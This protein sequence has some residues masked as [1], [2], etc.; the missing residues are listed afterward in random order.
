MATVAGLREVENKSSVSK[1]F[2]S[3]GLMRIALK[4]MVVGL[5]GVLSVGSYNYYLKATAEAPFV[6][7]SNLLHYSQENK[8][9]PFTVTRLPSSWDDYSVCHLANVLNY[10]AKQNPDS[11][12][13]RLFAEFSNT[14]GILPGETKP[15]APMNRLLMQEGY[16]AGF[17]KRKGP[18]I[19]LDGIPPD[20]LYRDALWSMDGWDRPFVTGVRSERVNDQE[21]RCVTTVFPANRWSQ[22]ELRA[23]DSCREPRCGAVSWG[24]ASEELQVKAPV[25]DLVWTNLSS[26]S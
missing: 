22:R 17:W 7:Q 12:L 2:V 24:Q 8:G 23:C 6:P 20:D 21:V 25:Q 13:T 10:H 15:G 11:D 3:A 26:V 5:L 16:H 18:W 14:V 1:P 4:A 19:D 9:E